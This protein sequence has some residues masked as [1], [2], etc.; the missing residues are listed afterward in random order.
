VIAC[1]FVF[2]SVFVHVVWFGCLSSGLLR[3]LV[4]VVAVLA[5]SSSVA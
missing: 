1:V 2:C 4:G 3:V 5:G